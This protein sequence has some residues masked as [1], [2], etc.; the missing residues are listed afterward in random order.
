MRSPSPRI[1]GRG[2]PLVLGLSVVAQL[3]FAPPA[4]AATSR[5][6]SMTVQGRQGLERGYERVYGPVRGHASGRERV[7]GLRAA[8]LAYTAQYELIRPIAGPRPRL[9]LV[10]AENRGNPLVLNALT[11][12]SSAA[13]PPATAVYPRKVARFLHSERLAYARVQW[14][15]GVAAGVPPSAQGLGEV[16]VRDF[17]RALARRYP[18]RALVGVSQGAFFVDTF[19]AEGFNAVPGGGRAYAQALTV[20]GTGNW[21]ALNQLAGAGAQNAYLRANGRPLSYRRM[22]RRART[23]P[24]LIDVANYTD[25]YRL[26]AGLTDTTPPP[27]GVRRYDWPSPHQSFSPAAVFGG[28]GCNGGREIPLNPLRYGPY[29]RAL[30]HGMARRHLPASRRFT[31]GP[32]PRTSPSFNGL[33]GVTVRVPRTDR[34]SQPRGG[35][36]FPELELPLGRLEPVS[37]SPALTTSPVAVCGNS[38]G[39]T[40]FTP[41]TVSKRYTRTTYLDR[42]ARALTTLERRGYLRS[43]DR[44][45]MLAA[46]AADYAAALRE[47]S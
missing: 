34:L 41:A 14:Q 35:V 19:I 23:D 30:V 13:G 9:L 43:A 37:L 40:P 45:S 46:A 24:T 32:R 10:E 47:G 4:V 25:F 6:T 11:P 38:G 3:L 16:I 8:G 12:G 20:D 26:R 5:V 31:L 29:L 33:P 21:M 2:A 18:R 42:Y 17:G 36:R 28:L 15:T 27:P 39:F 7:R 1:H 44:P 22:L